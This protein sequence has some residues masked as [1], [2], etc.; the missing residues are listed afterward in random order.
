MNLGK[1]R[2]N[3][4]ENKSLEDI[5]INSDLLI[6]DDLGAEPLTE[7]SKVEFLIC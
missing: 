5:L 4:N 6:I 7:F 2:F 1:S 3:P